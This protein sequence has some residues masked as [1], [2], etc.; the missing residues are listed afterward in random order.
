M[1][2][3]RNG[4]TPL[5]WAAKNGHEGI[6]KT[7][8]ERADVIPD[9]A[10]T[11]DGR[12]PLSWAAG[13]GHEGVVKMLL[14]REDVDYDQA[15]TKYGRTPLA[16]AI[17]NFHGRV[18]TILLQRLGVLDA[19]FIDHVNRTLLSWDFSERHDECMGIFPGNFDSHPTDRGSRT[20]L[21]PSAG[22]GD[23]REVDIQCRSHDPN[24][25]ITE[26]NVQPAPQPVRPHERGGALDFEDP[27]PQVRG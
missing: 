27:D 10:D 15:D 14:E 12:T 16:W 22:Q 9:Q 21:S 11:E 19:L 6:V 7:I 20:S 1:V 2:E 4:L 5:L 24:T 13:L 17:G 8:L 25:N 26:L 3:I 18:A 23:K